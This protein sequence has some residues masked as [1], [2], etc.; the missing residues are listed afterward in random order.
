MQRSKTLALSF[1]AGALL[2]GGALGFTVDRVFVGDR[3]CEKRGDRMAMRERMAAD[4]GL[5]TAQRAAVDSLLEK[6]HADMDAIMSQVR[7][8]L[9][10]VRTQARVDIANLLDDRQKARYERMLEEAKAARER[11]EGRR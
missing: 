5:T 2:I 10:S 9:D 1:L 7:P 8:Q 11:R 4:L 3:A 6:R